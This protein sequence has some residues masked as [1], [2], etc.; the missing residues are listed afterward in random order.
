VAVVAPPDD[1]A[2][3]RAA[4]EELHARW[5]AGSLDGAPLSDAWREKLSRATRVEE[6]A[7]VLGGLA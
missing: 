1:V 4:L 7:D 3:I 5:A 6:L 2:A